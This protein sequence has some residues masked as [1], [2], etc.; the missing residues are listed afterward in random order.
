MRIPLGS[1]KY[2]PDKGL[3]TLLDNIDG[4]TLKF[5]RN[6]HGAMIVDCKME[7]TFGNFCC[8]EFDG[9]GGITAPELG[10]L[11]RLMRHACIVR[12]PPDDDEENKV[13]V[14]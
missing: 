8:E 2:D 9:D 1:T 4:M 6:G 10:L 14:E 5:M 7:V 11:R 12:K 13:D 3:E